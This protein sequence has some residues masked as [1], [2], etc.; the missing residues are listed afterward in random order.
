M[1]GIVPADEF[2]LKHP[3]SRWCFNSAIFMLNRMV[4]N[5]MDETETVNGK[6]KRVWTV[7]DILDGKAY[8]PNQ[9][10]SSLLFA[11]GLEVMDG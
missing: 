10:I 6:T 3:W 4:E 5:K 9:Q 7:E 2:G 8:R 1:F 11:S